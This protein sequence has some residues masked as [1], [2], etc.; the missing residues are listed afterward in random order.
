MK[1]GIGAV[2]RIGSGPEADLVAHHLERAR[3]IGRGLGVTKIDVVER[4]ESRA[5]EV[6]RRR[7]EEAA[8]LLALAG[9]AVVIAV[10]E[11]GEAL[12]SRGFAA[13]LDP[14]ALGGAT[15]PC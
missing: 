12:D 8:A 2:G 6:R 7:D 14:S 11:R 10:D 5:A 15:S 1:I 4:P 3:R 9:E 13:L